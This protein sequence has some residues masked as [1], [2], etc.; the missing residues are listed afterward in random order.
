MYKYNKGYSKRSVLFSYVEKE[1]AN[2]DNVIKV[3]PDKDGRYF[4]TLYGNRI[5]LIPVKEQPKPAT[6][7]AKTDK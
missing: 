5:E 7:P 2:M 3:T 1:D 4:V 6:K